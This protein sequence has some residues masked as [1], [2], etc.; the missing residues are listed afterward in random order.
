MIS[1]REKL[2]DDIAFNVF[3]TELS[4]VARDAARSAIQTVNLAELLDSV[5][6]GLEGDAFEAIIEAGQS[7]KDKGVSYVGLS[8]PSEIRW[9]ND[10][11]AMTVAFD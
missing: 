3:Q 2:Y 8:H 1:D 11:D 5:L 9:E 6:P 4:R 7:M 10:G